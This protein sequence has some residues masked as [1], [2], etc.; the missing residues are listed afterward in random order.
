MREAGGGSLVLYQVT[1]VLYRIPLV[2]PAGACPYAA[3]P[4]IRN[5]GSSPDISLLTGTKKL[6]GTRTRRIYHGE[7]GFNGVFGPQASLPY[8][9]AEAR[10]SAAPAHQAHHAALTHHSTQRHRTGAI[11]HCPEHRPGLT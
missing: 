8:S 3:R 6:T 11:P 10:S 9:S 5:S 2:C 1:L 4:G 7:S